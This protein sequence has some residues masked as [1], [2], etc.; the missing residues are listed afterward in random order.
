MKLK[1]AEKIVMFSIIILC[2]SFAGSSLSCINRP[3]EPGWQLQ[4][5]DPRSEVIYYSIPL[6]TGSSF[7]LRYRHSVSSSQVSGTFEITAEGEFKPLLTRYSSFGPG[8]P[9]DYYEDYAVENGIITVYHKEESRREI[10]L[11]VTPLTEEVIIID[12]RAY[13]LYIFSDQEKLLVLSTVRAND[14]R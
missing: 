12:D 9:L 11:W 3:A 13:P 6:K 14:L 8:L 7:T 2:L 4:A 5:T 1:T 10:R